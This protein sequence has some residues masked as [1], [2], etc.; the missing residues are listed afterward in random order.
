MAI[1]LFITFNGW[2]EIPAD[3]RI[4]TEAYCLPEPFH[5]EPVDRVLVATA[6]LHNLQLMTGDRKILDYPHV[7]TLW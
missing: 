5:A 6:R 2:Q 7:E 3:L 1:F 4:V